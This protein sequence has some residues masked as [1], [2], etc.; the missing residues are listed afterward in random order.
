MGIHALIIFM[1]KKEN[2]RGRIRFYAKTYFS[3]YIARFFSAPEI[4]WKYYTVYSATVLCLRKAAKLRRYVI[5]TPS[6]PLFFVKV[7]RICFSFVSVIKMDVYR[8]HL[9]YAPVFPTK[10]LHSTNNILHRSIFFNSKDI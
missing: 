8:V 6:L 3:T 2:R 9:C 1:H 4:I 10:S 7:P 5:R